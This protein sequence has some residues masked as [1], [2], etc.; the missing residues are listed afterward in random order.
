MKR[1]KHKECGDNLEYSE[2]YDCLYCVK[3][4]EWLESRCSDSTCDFCKD[5]PEKPV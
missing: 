5:R 3:C 1:R 4:N 2:K